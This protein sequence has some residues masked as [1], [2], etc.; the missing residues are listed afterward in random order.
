MLN[1]LGAFFVDEKLSPHCRPKG[2]PAELNDAEKQQVWA[3]WL[4]AL[5]AIA[6]ETGDDHFAYYGQAFHFYA[7]PASRRV[8]LPFQYTPLLHYRGAGGPVD[9]RP[10]EKIPVITRDG[11]KWIPA[12]WYLEAIDDYYRRFSSGQVP[13]R[14]AV[15]PFEVLT[16]RIASGDFFDSGFGMVLTREPELTSTTLVWAATEDKLPQEVSFD[17]T[18]MLIRKID[19]FNMHAGVRLN[20]GDQTI[21]GQRAEAISRS[22]EKDVVGALNALR[23]MRSNP[24]WKF[25]FNLSRYYNQLLETAPSHVVLGEKEI[26]RD[27]IAPSLV[28]E[29]PL[30]RSQ[31]LWAF[32]DL[33]PER[34]RGAL[35]ATD[36]AAATAARQVLASSQ[37]PAADVDRVVRALSVALRTP[38]PADDNRD[39]LM[40]YWQRIRPALDEL[41][42]VRARGPQIG[43]ALMTLAAWEDPLP[44]PG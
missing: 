8:Y 6:H 39:T 17:A 33:T 34:V 23:G 43:A 38:K 41:A 10:G 26:V 12:L 4:T 16:R 28:D 29:N 24:N 21:D 36:R 1:E 44:H 9:I 3:E 30:V 27:F 40:A 18:G 11:V 37:V 2:G 13:S 32:R 25:R 42:K 22:M 35:G 31:T 20:Q 15:S 5:E 7:D 14:D 19:L